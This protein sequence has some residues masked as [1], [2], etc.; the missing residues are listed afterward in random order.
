[1]RLRGSN[2]FVLS[3][4]L[5]LTSAEACDIGRPST[6]FGTD[7]TYSKFL[8]KQSH[9]FHTCILGDFCSGKT[10]D[11]VSYVCCCGKIYRKPGSK[12]C[13]M[14]YYNPLKKTCCD[15]KRA[16]LVRR[17]YECS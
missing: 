6:D 5:H 15:H 14:K 12:C 13:G 16:N 2:S 4:H 17:R 10:Y 3:G 1:M 7:C 11:P 8:N 9:H